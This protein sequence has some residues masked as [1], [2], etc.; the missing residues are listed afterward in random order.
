MVSMIRRHWSIARQGAMTSGCGALALEMILCAAPQ[1]AVAQ[2]AGPPE[3]VQVC[4]PCHGVNGAGRDVETPN[5]AGQSGIYLYNQLVAFR[6]RTRQHPDMK[7]IARDL[8]I[9][10]I[11][12]IVAYYSILP[13]P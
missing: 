9:R 13:P 11:E 4:A 3:I 5:L 1:P 7:T 6:N 2:A 12:Q 10:E 8:S